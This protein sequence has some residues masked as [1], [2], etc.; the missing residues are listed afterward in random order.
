MSAPT[1]CDD[2]QC[3]AWISC[4][5]H[6]GRSREY[7]AMKVPEPKTKKFGRAADEEFCADYQ[8]DTPKAWMM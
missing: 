7:A 3:P 5:R 6:I 8:F 2:W 4:A 1:Y